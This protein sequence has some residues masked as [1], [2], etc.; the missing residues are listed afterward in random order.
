MEVNRDL[1]S[2]WLLNRITVPHFKNRMSMIKF[3]T[4]LSVLTEPVSSD[5]FGPVDFFT[6]NIKMY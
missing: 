4:G 5:L 1:I 2:K 6:M 3:I